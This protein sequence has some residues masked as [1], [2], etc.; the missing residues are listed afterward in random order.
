MA[1]KKRKTVFNLAPSTYGPETTDGLRQQVFAKT[2]GRCW[3]CGASARTVDHYFA[4]AHFPQIH[5]NNI[6]N[7]VPC[8][9]DCNQYKGAQ[10]AMLRMLPFRPWHADRLGLR[11]PRLYD[12]GVE[13]VVVHTHWG[14]APV[15]ENFP[16][17]TAPRVPIPVGISRPPTPMLPPK[18]PKTPP[19]RELSPI[20]KAIQNCSRVAQVRHP[21][22]GLMLVTRDWAE[23]HPELE[24][25][26]TT[27]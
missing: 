18:M 13:P 7:L 20:K 25:E 22:F 3:Y 2:G 11:S 26:T 15:V 8:C 14:K 27:I 19:L 17:N 24:M 6:D 21:K 12:F 5:P 16:L 1:K 10:D 23:A 4:R 9:R